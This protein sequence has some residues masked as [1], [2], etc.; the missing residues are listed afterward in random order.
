MTRALL[1]TNGQIA[2]DQGMKAYAVGGCVR[3]WFLG[4]SRLSDVDITVESDSRGLA[5]AIAVAL[6]GKVTA[7]HEQF[8]TATVMWKKRRIDVAM[9][10][11]ETYSHPGAYPRVSPGQLDDDLFRRDFTINAMAIALQPSH[12]GQLIDLFHGAKDLQARQLRILHARS[13]LD[14]PSRILRGVRF[15]CRFG[16]Q[17]EPATMKAQYTALGQG[18]LGWLN[19]GRLERELIAMSHEPD[20]AACLRQFAVLLEACGASRA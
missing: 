4:H 1:K 11:K 13:F 10:R 12:F 18:A 15:A 9:C 16:F 20:P 3:D 7:L 19:R 5:D 14:D 2:E 6:H 17:W 8:H